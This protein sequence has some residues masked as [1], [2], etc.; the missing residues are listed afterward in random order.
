MGGHRAASG[1][2]HDR[3]GR[4]ITEDAVTL[5][6]ARETELTVVPVRLLS[7]YSFTIHKETFKLHL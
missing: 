3:C 2:G 6:L 5:Q 1:G 4:S 7:I